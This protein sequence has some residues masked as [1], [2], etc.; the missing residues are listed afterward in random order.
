MTTEEYQWYVKLVQDRYHYLKLTY[1]QSGQVYKYEADK[2]TYSTK[3]HF[4]LWEEWDY[5]WTVFREILTADQLKIYEENLRESITRFEESLVEGDKG[6][7]NDIAYYQKNLDFYQHHFLP[8]ICK[9][10]FLLIGL[11]SADKS[12]IEYLKAEY[13][14]F[15][16]D[17]KKKI[18]TDHFRYNRTFQPNALKAA[19]LRHQLSYLWPDYS[20]FK[21]TMDQPT[22]TIADYLSSRLMN[23]PDATESML[24]K[25]FE[26]LKVFNEINV[27]E[28]YSDQRGWHVVIRQMTPEEERENRGMSLLLLEAKGYESTI[29]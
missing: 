6:N 5:E 10:L 23:Y 25:K 29:L 9:D 4:S 3:Y 8:D 18:L 11:P 22:K 14:K 26:E 20:G 21:H 15:L 2:N 19:L 16:N 28:H 13:R 17:V 7:L 24:I 12:K 27:K 1:A